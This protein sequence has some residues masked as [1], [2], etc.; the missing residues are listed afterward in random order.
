[1]NQLA[2]RAIQA[3]VAPVVLITSVA[4]ISGGIATI[5]AAVNDRMRV[6]AGERLV[7]V[8]GADGQV[9]PVERL[10][11]VAAERVR[12]I[13]AQLPLLLRRHGLLRLAQLCDYGAIVVLVVAMLAIAL[14][15][16]H[17]SRLAADAALVA[18]L[19]ATAGLLAGL[20]LAAI[21][22]GLSHDAVSLEVRDVLALGR[23]RSAE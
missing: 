4:I 2:I 3:M 10:T 16:P 8:A 5:Y 12:Q 11:G 7:L 6:L 17:D 23:A 13:D 22:V 21:S 1:V 14:S 20:V 15:V 9:V 19:A 18:V